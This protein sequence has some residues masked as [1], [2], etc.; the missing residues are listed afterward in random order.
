[1]RRIFVALAIAVLLLLVA[2][3]WLLADLNRFRP[4]A[5]AALSARA[6]FEI[7]IEGDLGWRL[8][9]APALSAT[10]VAAADGSWRAERVSVQLMH[11]S[12]ALDGVMSRAA[13]FADLGI[14]GL[15]AK[16]AADDGTLRIGLQ[17]AEILGG[18]GRADIGLPADAQSS[19][20]TLDLQIDELRAA[21]LEPWLG[22]QVRWQGALD[23]G[24]QLRL[25]EGG[26]RFESVATA[27]GSSAS[28]AAGLSGECRL[29]GGE[30]RIQAP[31]LNKL[32]AAA[33]RLAGD[34]REAGASALDYHGLRAA[35]TL[36]GTKHSLQANLDNL[37]L[38][39]EGE[40]SYL[41]D[42][43]DFMAKLTLEE[44]AVPRM[45]AAEQAAAGQ[46]AGAAGVDPA[47][48]ADGRAL[49]SLERRES[50]ASSDAPP[51]GLLPVSPALVGLPIPV[52]C[53]GSIQAPRCGLD[54]GAFAAQLAA[55]ARAGEGSPQ[56]RQL[57]AVIEGA[58]PPKYRKAAVSLLKLLAEGREE[59][60]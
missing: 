25:A 11:E 48:Q 13:A 10:S 40:Y 42:N 54:V 53:R 26:E 1:M 49:R 12:V 43:L 52:R 38:T 22:P 51:R 39:G 31:A 18:W 58:V 8:L 37:T 57:E 21:A 55:M 24:C 4:Q 44:S 23:F 17:A 28:L 46:S 34:F 33:A 60:G 47:G 16:A 5:E 35:W 14:K 15:S 20:W 50:V 9:P 2:G 56:A 3:A 30:G 59:D 7:R 6:G 36:A 19:E 45:N 32:L 41:E 27:G 29:A